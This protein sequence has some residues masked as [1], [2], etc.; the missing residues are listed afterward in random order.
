MANVAHTRALLSFAKV[1]NPSRIRGGGLEEG[2]R[3]SPG[4]GLGFAW[5]SRCVCN[6][7]FRAGEG[8]YLWPSLRDCRFSFLVCESVKSLVWGKINPNM[9]FFSKPYRNLISARLIF[10]L[11]G[12]KLI[13]K[14]EKFSTSP[15]IP[16]RRILIKILKLFG[17][18]ISA[19]LPTT[20]LS[21]IQRHCFLFSRNFFIKKPG[22]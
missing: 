2:W 13:F 20:I 4:P 19:Q 12:K 16:S 17:I 7:V 10:L 3:S 5:V 18:S 9:S 1:V 8:R 22:N 11:L 15:R 14:H 21:S 6:A